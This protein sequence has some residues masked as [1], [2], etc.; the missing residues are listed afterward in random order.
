M[1]EDIFKLL[2]WLLIFL[3]AY[4]RIVKRLVLQQ[5]HFTSDFYF[6]TVFPMLKFHMLGTV[7]VSYPYRTYKKSFDV[8]E[9]FPIL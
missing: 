8:E 5:I 2:S 6:I 3:K 7:S 9:V 1:L 4:K